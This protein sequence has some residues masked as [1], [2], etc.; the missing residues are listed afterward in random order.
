MSRLPNEIWMQ[1]FRFLEGDCPNAFKSVVRARRCFYSMG[2]PILFS[3]L[4]VSKGDP[5]YNFIRISTVSRLAKH[6]KT[7][8]F[9]GPGVTPLLRRLNVYDKDANRAFTYIFVET[10]KNH[11]KEDVICSY[12]NYAI[13][14]A[15]SRP[16]TQPLIGRLKCIY[17]HQDHLSHLLD[18]RLDNGRS[19]DLGVFPNLTA[20]ET[21]NSIFLRGQSFEPIKDILR[22][23]TE[24]SGLDRD[25]AS[26]RTLPCRLDGWRWSAA[27]IGANVVSVTLHRIQDILLSDY[28]G[29]NTLKAVKHLKIDI[30]ASTWANREEW[31]SL[32]GSPIVIATWLTQISGLETFTLIQNPH[33]DPSI[34]VLRDLQLRNCRSIRSVDLVHVTT[35]GHQLLRF[36][37][38]HMGSLRGLRVCEP[39]MFSGWWWYHRICMEERRWAIDI[40]ELGD[41]YRPEGISRFD[42]DAK[43]LRTERVPRQWDY[44]PVSQISIW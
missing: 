4:R 25:T 15:S 28:F 7:I 33:L 11:N 32:V 34:D 17:W 42:W 12:G 38:Y 36:V 31:E 35:T 19:L 41:E 29:A 37:D 44:A 5:M 13:V 27:A 10:L 23:C 3:K 43:L 24:K 18:L 30:S 26:N 9:V 20:V 8:V 21:A 14:R 22:Q 2:S 39:V 1:I 40:L 6:V 16:S